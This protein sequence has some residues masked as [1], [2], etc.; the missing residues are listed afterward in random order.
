MQNSAEARVLPGALARAKWEASGLSAKA[1]EKLQFKELTGNETGR[2][3]P[4]FHPVSSLYIPYFDLDGCKTQFFRVR[5]LAPLPGFAALV[6]KPQRYA[7]KAG[8]LNEVYLPPVMKVSWRDVSEDPNV[9]VFF[10]EGELKSAAASCVG[11]ATIGLGG[12][13]VWRATKRLIDFLPA[14]EEFEWKG[15]SVVIVFDSDAATNPNVVRAQCRL[16]EELTARGA[17]PA[18]ASLP[19]GVDGAKQGLDDFLVKNGREALDEIIRDAPAYPEALALW[20]LN[21]EVVYVE[22]PGIL[23][24]RDTG[25]LIRPKD[26]TGHAYSN[27]YYQAH[28]QV[29]KGESTSTV[30]KKK[31]LAPK[32]MGWEH[33]F[34][35]S[36]MAYEPGK[37]E[38]EDGE[39]NTWPGWGCEP[40]R[41]DVGPWM[42]LLDFLFR[43]HPTEREWFEKWCAYPIQNPGAKLYTNTLLWGLSGGTGKTLVAYSLMPIYGKNAV[44]IKNKDLQGG[45]NGWLSKKQFIYCDEITGGDRKAKQID[46]DWFKGLTTQKDARINE[47]YMPE[48]V[49]RDHANYYAASN[50]PDSYALEDQDRR[51]FVHEVVGGPAE[52]SKY[53]IYDKWLKGEGPKHLFDHLLRLSV[54]GFNPRERAP[55]TTARE[56]MIDLAKSDLGIW[57]SRLRH[58]PVQMLM[59][60]G[61]Q[62]AEECD[63]LPMTSLLRAYDPSGSSRV[64]MVG[65]GRELKKAGF[66]SLPSVRTKAGITRLYV[67]RH[68]KQWIPKAVSS[69][70]M[71]EAVQHYEQYTE[72]KF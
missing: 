26:F 71:K 10:T 18:V 17:V 37:G 41:G 49:V 45:F 52:R 53:E 3:G 28:E 54:K 27:R 5:Y 47:K 40:K 6:E 12:V 67:I 23:V 46:M 8:T 39:L 58:D 55:S 1:A 29:K 9:A 33:R 60:L 68:D 72:G 38:Y 48:Y 20:S 69:L 7:Q 62:L 36:R 59:P 30:L 13:D 22:E 34:T 35:L 63:L 50:H 32:W 14:L 4:N 57:C 51:T 24:R 11:L 19:A 44:E 64:S 2:L 42:W 15:R 25:Q 16:A 66:V 43:D 21:E 65:M 31:P 61:P 70:T 56:E